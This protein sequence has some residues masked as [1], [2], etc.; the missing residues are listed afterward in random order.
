MGVIPF[1][2]SC[3]FREQ[4]DDLAA[5]PILSRARIPEAQ[6]IVQPPP[7]PAMPKIWLKS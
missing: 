7:F 5:L 3:A 1:P 4:E 2:S 6:V